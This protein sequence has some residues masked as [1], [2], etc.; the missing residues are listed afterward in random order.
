MDI[1]FLSNALERGNDSNVFSELT[2]SL[3]CCCAVLILSHRVNALNAHSAS[4]LA[5]LLAGSLSVVSHNCGEKGSACL[6]VRHIVVSGEGV[7]HRVIYSETYVREAHTC[8]VLTESHTLATVSGVCNCAAER[9]SDDLDSFEVEHIRK[10]PSASGDV[11]LDRVSERVHTG[12]R[13]KRSGHSRHHIG[14]NY[15]NDGNVVGVNTNELSLLLNVGDN[16]VD[17]NLSGSTCGGCNCDGGNAGVLR[18][19]NA[20]KR[21]NVRVLGVGDDDADSLCGI[22]RGAAADSYDAVSRSRLERLNAVLY[23]FYSRIGL[24]VREYAVFNT[25]GVEKIGDLLGDAELDKVGVG[26]DKGLLKASCLD[27]CGDSRNSAC[28]VIGGFVKHKLVHGDTS[29]HIPK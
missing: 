27:L 19:S 6:S 22:H 20:L 4:D 18:G 3:N 21:A 24:D 9:A 1:L 5:V 12:S 16:V 28:S 2:N 10:L 13:G 7:S 26:S 25:L 14:V 23:V 8:N 17:G 15:R 11:A 29:F